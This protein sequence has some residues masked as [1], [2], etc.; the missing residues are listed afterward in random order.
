MSVCVCVCVCVCVKA[1]EVPRHREVPTPEYSAVQSKVPCVELAVTAFLK[2]P[3]QTL[4]SISKRKRS[5]KL[6]K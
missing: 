6:R 3:H 4:K 2:S 5:R 1:S